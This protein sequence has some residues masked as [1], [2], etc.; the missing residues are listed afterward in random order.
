[1]IKYFCD[2]ELLRA[3]EGDSGFDLRS[4]RTSP[5]T[6]E[7]GERWLVPTSLRLE[8]PRGVEAQIRSRS[9]LA[10]HHGIIVL[11]APGTIDSGYRGE[12]GVTLI[13]HDKR[14]FVVNP[15]ERIAQLVFALVLCP[16]ELVHPAVE[17]LGNPGL[18]RV[19]TIEELSDSD[20]GAGGH[21]STG[22]T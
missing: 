8:M 9:G 2:Y 6:L 4:T 17:S 1:M 12:I 3:R 5:R 20:R 14:A 13:N 19:A 10:L 11:N 16:E 7:P 21:G 15:G 22:L 18:F